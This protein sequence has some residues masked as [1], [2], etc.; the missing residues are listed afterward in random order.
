MV[1]IQNLTHTYSSSRGIFDITLDIPAF[2]T[3]AVIGPS[4][5]GKSTLLHLVAGL[6]EP[7]SGSVQTGEG[8]PVKTGLV[9]QKDA[10]YPWLSALDNV[11]LGVNG[12]KREHLEEAMTLMDELGVAETA[13]RYPAQLS[14]GERQRVSLART[15]ILKPDLLLLDEPTASLDDFSKEV[16]QNLLLRIQLN[17]PVTTLFVTHSL[18]EALF[19]GQEILIMSEGKI[20]RTHRNSLYPDPEA[21]DHKDFYQEVLNLRES[22]K[23][24][25]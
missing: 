15:L 14:G 12:K 19:L 23:A 11:L 20:H 3:R 1:R 10:L 7:D 2:Q 22:L 25:V 16:L 6:L 24:A 8:K 13:D 5:C 18:E 17:K 21:R 9:Q 4:G